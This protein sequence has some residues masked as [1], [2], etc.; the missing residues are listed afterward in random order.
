M[1][2]Q[3]S[4]RQTDLR[5]I[6]SAFLQERLRD[7]LE[8]SDDELKR[9]ELRDQFVPSVW[10]ADAARR[11]GQIQ[12][13]T[14]SLKPLH[15]DARG[16]SLFCDPT[17]LESLAELGSHALGSDLEA[18]VVGN[19]AALD[20]YRFL[21]LEHEGRTLLS[22]ATADDSD[23]AA[24]LSD[25]PET[26]RSWMAGF[27]G[28]ATPRGSLSSHT[29]AKQIYW[30]V[31][32]NPHDDASYHLLAP[33]YPTSLVHRVYQTLQAD[34]FGETAKAAREARKAGAWH[35][36]PVH[37]YPQLAIQKL[38]GTKPQNISQL[39]SERRGDNYLLASLPPT[40]K[41]APVKPLFGVESIFTVFQWHG[42]VRE[43]VKQLRRFMESDPNANVATR[44]RRDGLVEA[45][46]DE[47]VQFTAELRELASGWT[48]DIR[49]ELS[50]AH[51]AWLD[52][53]GGHALNSDAIDDLASDVANWLNAQLRDRLPVGDPEYL[54]WRKQTVD[55]FKEM[56]REE[57]YEI[58]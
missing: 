42:G 49:C 15:P 44:E 25:S 22:L 51:A 33:L 16:S 6:V 52:P 3:P 11:A 35:E 1:S 8:K 30:L 23:F 43:T 58:A 26:G 2:Q 28:I 18:D 41:S 4:T 13:V 45:L 55:L 39:N 54:H 10:L 32:D 46:L 14:H 38:G 19:A 24:A 34:R 53:F 29:H 37:E 12:V 17:A 27:A 48:A 36:S 50:R 5:D 9:D 56:E 20:V 21:K 31:G 57:S 47:F 40:W 7:K